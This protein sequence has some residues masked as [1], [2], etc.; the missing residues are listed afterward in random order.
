MR[1]P[2]TLWSLCALVFCLFNPVAK[3]APSVG[4]RPQNPKPT[5]L[6]EKFD[7]WRNGT[8]LRGANIWQKYN[9]PKECPGGICPA[10]R[11]SDIDDLESWKANYVNISYPGLYGEDPNAGNEY[12][13]VPLVQENLLLLLDW[14]RKNDLFVVLAFRTGPGRREEIF[15]KQLPP[16]RVWSDSRAQTAWVKMWRATA[17]LLKDRPEVVGYDLMVEPDTGSDRAGWQSLAKRILTEIR[18][19]DAKTPV[20]IE[21]ADGGGVEALDDLKPAVLDPKGELYV[22]Y[23]VHQYQPYEYSQQQ[24]GQEYCC[25]KGRDCKDKKPDE[26]EYVEFA[27]G[28][29]KQLNDAYAAIGRWRRGHELTLGIKIPVAVNEFGVV[30]WAGKWDKRRRPKGPVPDGHVFMEAQQKLIEGL[31][32]NYAVWKWDPQDCLGDDDFNF[33]HGQIFDNHGDVGNLLAK[34]IRDFWGHNTV[35]LAD[36]LWARPPQPNPV[37]RTH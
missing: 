36:A 7:L 9:D 26:D 8:L 27:K 18:A 25:V 32:A 29:P 22:V 16:S 10:Y 1:K 13:P 15:N 2:G 24:E 12:E 35:T 23:C 37:N 20:L 28:Y 31:G 17:D 14:C 3:V 21:T 5:H 33:R 30:R 11:K 19:V 6:N 34:V 4:K